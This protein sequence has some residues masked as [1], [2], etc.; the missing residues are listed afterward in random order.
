M[1][2]Y[3]PNNSSSAETAAA[4]LTSSLLAR[5][6]QAS[7]AVDP[8]AHEGV[9]IDMRP[10]R[11]RA[12]RPRIVDVE[13]RDASYAANPGNEAE[14]QASQDN[15]RA[16]PPRQ[17]QHESDRDSAPNTPP[18]AW[19]VKQ[20][21]KRARLRAQRKNDGAAVLNAPDGGADKTGVRATVKFRMP[22]ADFVRLRYASRSM[23]ESC[24]T[25]LLDALSAYLDAN[26]VEAIPEETAATEAARLI[27]I[28]RRVRR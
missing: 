17:I 12:G 25:I 28:A 18:D 27:R 26:E 4:P 14:E 9:E 22:A 7:P 2:G 13:A 15:V 16:F 3:A 23:R 11:P 6:G 8:Y 20:A 10:L 24:Q 19:T 21:V 5:K 1:S